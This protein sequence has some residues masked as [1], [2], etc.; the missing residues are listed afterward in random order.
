MTN[1]HSHIDIKVNKNEGQSV[2]AEN[3]WFIDSDYEIGIITKKNFVVWLFDFGD[4]Y[5]SD[6]L[7]EIAHP[8]RYLTPDEYVTVRNKVMTN[9]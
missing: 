3:V 5:V 1:L 4:V 2:I 7:H 9:G 6:D 8:I